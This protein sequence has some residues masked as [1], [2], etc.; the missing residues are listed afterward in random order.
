MTSRKNGIR[1]WG[2]KSNFMEKPL[3]IRIVKYFKNAYITVEG[4]QNTS[5]FFIIREGKVHISRREQ[6]VAEERGNV[7]KPGDFFGVVSSLSG[8]SHIENAQALNDVSLVAVHKDQFSRLIQDNATVAIK[9]LL[10]FSR[11]MRYLNESL[12]R[13]TLKKIADVN[14]DHLF[15]VGEYY[16]AQR[17]FDLANYAYNQY[18]KHCPEGAN[19]RAAKDK[20]KRV[21]QYVKS[22]KILFGPDELTRNYPKDTM[23][24][25]EGEPG[26]EVYIIKSGL[27]KIA[28]VVKDGEMLL[29]ILRPG[30]IFGEMALL[31]SKPRGACAISYEACELMVVNRLNFHQILRSQ[32]QLITHM[33]TLLAERIWLS[34][35]QLANTRILDPLGRMYDMLL[36]QLE[37]N[38]VNLNIKHAYQFDFGVMELA[39][40]AGVSYQ[41]GKMAMQKLLQNRALKI[42]RE[43]ICVE[44]ILEFSRQAGY[45]RKMQ[46]VTIVSRRK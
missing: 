4:D 30:D 21:A 31:E 12:T 17:H 42:H 26:E 6:V 28:K 24:F 33:I 35:K 32:P 14:V 25:S 29:S 39:G 38:H 7:L 2:Q 20:L 44:N 22:S 41:E 3:Q 36:I 15:F 13:I 27:V 10:E 37:K 16:A 23:I 19:V 45:F 11:R 40:M 46:D 9:I 34:Y 43:K 18:I 1:E 8:H 5:Q